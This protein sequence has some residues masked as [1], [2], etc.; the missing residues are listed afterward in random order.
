MYFEVARGEWEGYYLSSEFDSGLGVWGW[1][2]AAYWQWTQG[3]LKCTGMG[4][5]ASGSI[6]KFVSS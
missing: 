5:H 3:G 6:G 1:G 2:G 4:I